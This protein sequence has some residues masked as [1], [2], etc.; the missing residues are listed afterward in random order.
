M[1]TNNIYGRQSW[2][3]YVMLRTWSFFDPRG[4]P[5]V[6]AS[7]DHYFRTCC[8][9]V[10]PTFQNL[11]KQNKVQARIVIATAGEWIIDGT[12]VLYFICLWKYHWEYWLTFMMFGRLMTSQFWLYFVYKNIKYLNLI[13]ISMH[14]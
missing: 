10:R 5:I 2:P 3:T 4:R 6:T 1:L 8:L 12:R 13:L 11:T 9:Y 14:C 7:S